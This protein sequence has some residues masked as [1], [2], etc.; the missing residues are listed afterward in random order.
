MGWLAR[1]RGRGQSTA[2]RPA[3]DGDVRARRRHIADER[4]DRL[5]GRGSRHDR[6][7]RPQATRD[8]I[9]RINTDAR[10]V[11]LQVA[12][13]IPI[14]ADL[15]GLFNSFRMMRLPDPAPSRSVEDMVLG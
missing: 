10:P 8:E 3:G 5:G 9:V 4:V 13:L 15:L 11:A 2:R 6:Q 12:L 14:L 1:D 7:R